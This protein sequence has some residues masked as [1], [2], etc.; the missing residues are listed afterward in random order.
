MIL[1]EIKLL[2]VTEVKPNIVKLVEL[3]KFEV[4]CT[5]KQ[6]EDVILYNEEIYM[7]EEQGKA[8]G[9]II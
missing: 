6:F 9:N 8:N 2:Q 7:I 4:K 5:N 1:G 3:T